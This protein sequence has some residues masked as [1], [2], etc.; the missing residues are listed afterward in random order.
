MYGWTG[1]C[2]KV[3]LTE[4]KI[5]KEQIPDEL[6]LDY[7]GG[8]GL[9]SRTLFD[10][11]KPNTDALSPDNVLMIAPGPL[12]GT[13]APGSA[14]WTITAKSALASG[15]GDGSGGGDFTTE[16]KFAGYD[17]I[18]FYGRSPE[19]VYLWINNGR[20]ELRNASHLMGKSPRDT[21]KLLQ[22]ELKDSEIRVLCIGL[23][24][25]NQA[26][27]AKVF[28]NVSRAGGKGGLGAIMG[29]KNIKAVAVRGTGSIKIAKPAEFLEAVR[30][31]YVGLMA[32]SATRIIREQGTLWLIRAASILRQL[33]TRNG[34]VGYFEGWENISS[35]AF[36]SQYAVKH[37]G[38]AACPVSCSHYYRVKD[39]PYATHGESNEY[40]TT[41]PFG[42]KCGID[43]LAAILKMHSICDEL[44]LDTHSCGGTIG[45]AMHCWQEGLI[46]A[47]DTG[48]IDLS[49]GNADSV[50]KLLPLMAYRQ[51]FG[52]ILAE[53]SQLAS[54]QIPG[55][56]ICLKT[57]K[58]Q[59]VS[60]YFPGPGTNL[61]DALAYATSTTGAHHMRGGIGPKVFEIP[62][63]RKALGSQEAI[64][65]LT[66]EPHSPEG[67]GIFL[68]LDQDFTAFHNCLN[69][70]NWVAGERAGIGLDLFA[71]LVSSATGV[72]M[73]GDDLMKV[74]ERV[75]NIEKAF[76]IREG[77]GKKDDTLPHS[78]F[79]EKETS[80]GCTGVN[81]NKFQTMLREYYQF[82]GWNIEG[83]P[84][85]QKLDEL[86]L[87]NIAQ[88]IGAT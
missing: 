36:E 11:V 33:S 51:G 26:R 63:L 12:N 45:F 5:I 53:G 23:A 18:I 3:Y 14:R 72:D 52:R 49:W 40:G 2:L 78:Y 79:V 77:M 58:G 59:E 54:K 57:I 4:G 67:K 37:H 35:E 56:E 66:M 20:F 44:G 43:N 75:S 70:C 71:R 65:R 10:A 50:I 27:V 69:I 38:C 64:K 9:N 88:Q 17:Q 6:R 81:K 73:S 13:A 42:S 34:Q 19:P 47:K 7:L 28:T 68:A 16:L 24:G 74:G 1:Y 32:S 80:Y 84:T 82:R 61:V 30:Q 31:A 62:Q 8:R 46:T 86:G 87:G 60:A 15:L 85:I 21:T 76:N 48:N 29:S 39:G 22:Q 41:Y 25:E 83:I 55:S